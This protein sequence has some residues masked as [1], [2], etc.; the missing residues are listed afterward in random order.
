M[1]KCALL[2]FCQIELLAFDPLLDVFSAPLVPALG[3]N[4]FDH[5]FEACSPHHRFISDPKRKP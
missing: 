2:I 3:P 4:H 1:N 5:H